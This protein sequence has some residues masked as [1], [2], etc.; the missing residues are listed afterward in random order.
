MTAKTRHD[1]L[2]PFQITLAFSFR[3]E[4]GEEGGR[5]TLKEPQKRG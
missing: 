1:L 3:R 2:V 4:F 5:E